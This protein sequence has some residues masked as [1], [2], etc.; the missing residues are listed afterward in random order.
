MPSPFSCYFRRENIQCGFLN[1]IWTCSILF[2]DKYSCTK[3]MKPQIGEGAWLTF[4]FASSTK[5]F[6]STSAFIAGCSFPS[7]RR[8]KF[9][10]SSPSAK[11][12]VLKTK[13]V[14]I[15]T[16]IMQTLETNSK[17]FSSSLRGYK[18]TDNLVGEL[19][20]NF[21]M[22]KLSFHPCWKATFP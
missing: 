21:L 9:F 18:D 6:A 8:M 3:E 16:F 11:H 4:W 19:R 14:K 5:S 15:K 10:S 20:M 22:T 1:E 17:L 12:M 7:S 13:R 2:R